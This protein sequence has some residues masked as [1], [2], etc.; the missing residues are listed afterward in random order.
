[1]KKKAII[2]TVA[3]FSALTVT[4]AFA[5]GK[6][7]FQ[8]LKN[9]SDSILGKNEVTAEQDIN[10]DNRVDVFDMI[11]MR[12]AFLGTGEFSEQIIDVSEENVK[13]IG[14]NIYDENNIAWLVQ[15]GSAVEFTVT[16]KSAEITIN[17]D[18]FVES[19]EK[20]RPRYA[21]IVDDKIIL[22]AILSVKER[23]VELFSGD[24][25]RTAVVKV[26]HLSEANNGAVGVS[27]IKVNS[28]MPV[29]VA[30]LQ[31]K[32][33]QI[34]FIGDSITCAYGVEGKDQYENY[35]TSTEN[36]MKSYA[37]LTAKQLDADYSA[38]SY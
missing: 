23:T 18:D 2:S 25:S 35:M 5:I 28:D 32:S 11:E 20:Y 36:F 29:P 6:Y 1:M 15:S 9:L 24:E 8:D 31:K 33:L 4:S 10:G 22:D 14:R 34:E 13:Y 26:I 17:G 19:D 27:K 37:Y 38:V 21:V 30:P 7:S 3:V 16:G 12:K